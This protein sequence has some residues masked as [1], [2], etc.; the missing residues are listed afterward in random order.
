MITVRCAGREDAAAIADVHVASWR[1]AYRDILPAATLAALSVSERQAGWADSLARGN[2]TILVAER[3]NQLLGFLAVGPARDDDMPAGALEI[4]VL[5]VAPASWSQGAGRALCE[6]CRAYARA[7][8]APLI[9][10]W[11]LAA[12]DRAR[13]FYSSV[14]FSEQSG[15]SR[16]YERDG[17]TV[18][19][20]R[21]VQA[22]AGQA[23]TQP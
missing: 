18:W 11:V 14:G 9:S 10:L 8:A 23:A 17:T 12:N 4:V 20:V 19:Q 13:R 21:Y 3:N 1:A 7:Q 22:L 5:Y 2:S 15:R 6:A 16:P